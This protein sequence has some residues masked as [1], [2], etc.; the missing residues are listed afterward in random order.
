MTDISDDLRVLL[1]EDSE[2][3]ASW[4]QRVLTKSENKR[5]HIDTVDWLSNALTAMANRNYDVVLLDLGL[6][7]SRG[8]ETLTT[9]LKVAGAT[10]VIVLTGHDEMQ[11]AM[12]CLEEGAQDFQLKNDVKT[13]PLERAILYAIQRR[14]HDL[15]GKDLI[16]ASLSQFSSEDSPSIAMLREHMQR[17]P[18]AIEEIRGY[19]RRNA[20][21]TTEDVDAILDAHEIN[22]VLKEMRDVLGG[23][24][25][26]R[27][28]RSSAKQMAHQTLTDLRVSTSPS[29]PPPPRPE[30]RPKA[31]EALLEVIEELN[32]PMEEG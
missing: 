7:D 20:S 25:R 9:F 4:L 19:L 10:P 14:H 29:S 32:A 2:E 3:D 22:T 11:L 12:D 30:T 17:I 8:L 18:D 21:H 23:P 31:K 26:K 28:R 6:P 15:V 13:R 1:V 27:K 5:F 16:K 24:T